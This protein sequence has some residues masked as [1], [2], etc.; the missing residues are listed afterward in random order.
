MSRASF[1]STNGTNTHQRGGA[2]PLSD[3][4]TPVRGACAAQRA[5]ALVWVDEATDRVEVKWEGFDGRSNTMLP[6]C[7]S[8]Q[9]YYP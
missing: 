3:C 6:A 4:S 5:H 8:L 1:I 9:H 2:G 7:Y